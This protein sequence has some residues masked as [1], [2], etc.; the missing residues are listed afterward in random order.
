MILFWRTKKINFDQNNIISFRFDVNIQNNKVLGNLHSLDP[1]NVVNLNE[2]ENKKIDEY[3][4]NLIEGL[5]QNI[6]IEKDAVI[7]EFEDYK[8]WAKDKLP[9]KY[10]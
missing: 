10:A 2:I 7:E 6:S 9:C 4:K 3:F 5:P 8:L 1:C